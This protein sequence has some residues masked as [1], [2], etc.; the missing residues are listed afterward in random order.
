[1]NIFCGKQKSVLGQQLP[2]SYFPLIRGH[3]WHKKQT[4]RIRRGHYRSNNFQ[5]LRKL[6]G[7]LPTS[8][9]FNAF[10][11]GTRSKKNQVFSNEE[12]LTFILA[13]SSTMKGTSSKWVLED[14]FSSLF[15]LLPSSKIFLGA[16]KSKFFSKASCIPTSLKGMGILNSSLGLVLSE[17]PT[18]STLDTSI[19]KLSKTFLAS[20]ATS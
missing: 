4:K 9:F 14:P 3:S 10:K 13:K 1:M 18:T 15:G 8:T 11:L 16:I 12:A 2:K 20:L 7:Y 19:L 5:D 17:I 6:L